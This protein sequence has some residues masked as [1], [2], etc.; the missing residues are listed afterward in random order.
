MNQN[1]TPLRATSYAPPNISPYRRGMRLNSGTGVEGPQ[2]KS[3]VSSWW[4]WGQWASIRT[5]WKTCS[6]T[7]DNIVTPHSSKP[8]PPRLGALR[9]CWSKT[10]DKSTAP[11]PFVS[12]RGRWIPA[13]KTS[14]RLRTPLRVAN[15]WR[16]HLF[17][18]LMTLFYFFIPKQNCK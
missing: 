11:I 16:L 15:E 6:S 8:T 4:S 12:H 2:T 14:G 13:T 1:Q 3:D 7:S 18:I 9:S 17:I 5:P 10:S